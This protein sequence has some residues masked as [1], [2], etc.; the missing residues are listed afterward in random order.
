MSG[1][2]TTK[3]VPTTTSEPPAGED[4]PGP[5]S[6]LQTPPSAIE[7]GLR[8]AA[9]AFHPSTKPPVKDKPVP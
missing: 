6:G 2:K 7:R 3:D 1:D 5:G 4:I 9:D 8:E